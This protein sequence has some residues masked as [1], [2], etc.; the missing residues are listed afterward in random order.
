M[1]APSMAASNENGLWIESCQNECGRLCQG[2]GTNMA[3]STKYFTIIT[4][5]PIIN[6]FAPLIFTHRMTD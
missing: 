3:I 5:R 2:R 1:P 4:H 6:N